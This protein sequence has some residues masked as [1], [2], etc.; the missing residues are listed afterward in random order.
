MP[1]S[2]KKGG[3]AMA[4]PDVCKT[5]APPAPPVPIPYPNIAQIAQASKES[6]KVKICGK[7]GCTIKTQVPRSN[8]DEAGTI[9]GMVSSCN[10]GKL[11]YVKG[12]SKVKYEGKKA[13]FVSAPTKQNKGNAVGAQVAPSQT[14]VLIMP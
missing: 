10:M 9:G 3:M 5:P 2:C 11:E 6:K 1:A 14:K 4:F 13:T 7:G 8:G 12:S